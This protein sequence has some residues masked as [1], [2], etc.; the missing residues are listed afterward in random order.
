MA[1]IGQNSSNGKENRSC[2]FGFMG[3]GLGFS[4]EIVVN[5]RTLEVCD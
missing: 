5:L 4:I 3:L 1:H 2:N